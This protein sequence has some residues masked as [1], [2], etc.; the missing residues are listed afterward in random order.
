L[1]QLG[2]AGHDDLEKI[3]ILCLEIGEHSYLFQ[4]LL[5]HVLGFINDKHGA[6]LVDMLIQKKLIETVIEG[7][8][9]SVRSMHSKI[10]YYHFQKGGW[11]EIS[12]EYK[13]GIN[14]GSDFAE[15]KVDERG[16]ARTHIPCE[17]DKTLIVRDPI[18]K[19]SKSQVM[20]LA[21]VKEP[22]IRQE[23]KRFAF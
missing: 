9:T 2:L 20:V 22:R 4:G 5:R 15:E 7:G 12:I 11:I 1:S 14:I 19:M 17:Y 6:P 3:A 21:C 13:G 16:F 23:F 8:S 10:F 18:F